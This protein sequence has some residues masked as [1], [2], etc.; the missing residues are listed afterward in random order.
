MQTLIEDVFQCKVFNRYGSREVGGVACSCEKSEKLHVAMWHSH[1]EILNEKLNPVKPGEMGKIYITTLNNF[2][3]PLIRYDIG[4]IAVKA[5]N[6]QCF[7]GRGMALIKKVIGR[8]VNL[9]KTKEGVLIDGEYFTHLLYFKNWVGKFQVIQKRFNLIEIKIVLNN[10]KSESDMT[11]IVDNIK[12]V[13]GQDCKVEFEFVD[14][15]EPLKSGKYLYT[16]S[17]VE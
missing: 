7:C 2:S 4:D 12:I 11:E 14:D 13:M 15:I 16:V 10:K 1:I 5:E 3:M 8:D 17:E 9:F 6:E